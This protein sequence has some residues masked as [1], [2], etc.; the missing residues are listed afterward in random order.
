MT[1]DA[2]FDALNVEEEFIDSAGPA[3]LP[4]KILPMEIHSEPPRRALGAEDFRRIAEGLD[5]DEADLDMLHG[6]VNRRCAPEVFRDLSFLM[7]GIFDSPTKQIDMIRRVHELA[8]R[9]ATALGSGATV[10]APKR[11]GSA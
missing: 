5:L 4:R 9:C 2:A 10:S 3:L 11:R 8:R 7:G 1:P 6:M